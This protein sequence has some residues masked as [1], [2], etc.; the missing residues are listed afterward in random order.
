LY[1]DDR[2]APQKS[3]EEEEEGKIVPHRY[4]H[5]VVDVVVVVVVD[6]TK[7]QIFC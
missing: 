5:N 4:L 1:E 3:Y 2:V 6:T 7:N